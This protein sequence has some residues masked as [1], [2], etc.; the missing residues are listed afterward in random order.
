MLFFDPGGRSLG[1]NCRGGNFSLFAQG[2]KK[3]ALLPVPVLKFC[4]KGPWS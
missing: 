1:M 3:P 4:S 2:K